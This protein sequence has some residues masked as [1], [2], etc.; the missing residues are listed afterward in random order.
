MVIPDIFKHETVA[1]YR[2]VAALSKCYDDLLF[3]RGIEHIFDQV[4][5]TN[6]FFE[7]HKPWKMK[8]GADLSTIIF[9][10]YETVRVVSLLLQPVVPEFADK[11]LS[12]LGLSNEEQTLDTAKFGGGSSLQL[13]G[14][15]LGEIADVKAVAE[16]LTKL[17]GGLN[18]PKSRNSANGTTAPPSTPTKNDSAPEKDTKSPIVSAVPATPTS[19]AACVG[20]DTKSADSVVPAITNNGSTNVK[21]SA[22]TATNNDAASDI[23]VTSPSA[24]VTTTTANGNTSA[25][26]EST[27]DQQEQ[28]QPYK[29]SARAKSDFTVHVSKIFKRKKATERDVADDITKAFQE[30]GPVSDVRIAGYRLAADNERSIYAFVDFQEKE[31][32]EKIFADREK[33]NEGRVKASINIPALSFTGEVIIAQNRG[34]S[35]RNFYG[36]RRAFGNQRSAGNNG[37]FGNG[38][39]PHRYPRYNGQSGNRPPQSGARNH[40]D[41]RQKQNETIKA[42]N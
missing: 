28:Q 4:R 20:G 14:R 9:L 2:I 39:P 41:N 36:N 26:L 21:L 32:F 15:N 22:A 19:W 3:Y 37:R 29:K 27:Q 17:T 24:N 25:D 34:S 30:F 1:V 23:T 40:S 42:D 12:R 18:Q 11:A 35:G 5:N 7:I 8:K 10:T 16:E 31:D 33:D 38:R 13:Y 6:A